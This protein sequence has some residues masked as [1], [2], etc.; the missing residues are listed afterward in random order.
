MKLKGD[1]SLLHYTA[2]IHPKAEAWHFVL[3]TNLY[4]LVQSTH[5]TCKSLLTSWVTGDD[6]DD[7]D[8]PKTMQYYIDE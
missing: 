6:I 7:K 5:N 3:A 8:E 2:S 4:N 1:E